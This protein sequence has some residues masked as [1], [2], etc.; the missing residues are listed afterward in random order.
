MGVDE[1]ERAFLAGEIDEDSGQNG[2][3]EHVGEIARMK[4]VAIVD[5]KSPPSP[6]QPDL[7]G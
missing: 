2:M 6:R 5:L 4:G 1:T 3:L 7:I